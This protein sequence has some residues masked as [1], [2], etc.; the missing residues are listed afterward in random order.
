MSDK[1]KELIQASIK[2]LGV[3]FS[4]WI[5]LL[6]TGIILF[7]ILPSFIIPILLPMIGFVGGMMW[8]GKNDQLDFASGLSIIVYIVLNVLLMIGIAPDIYDVISLWEIKPVKVQ[9][10]ADLEDVPPL[11]ILEFDGW[12]TD[13]KNYTRFTKRSTNHSTNSTTTI[14]IHA[15]PL[16][17]KRK[18]SEEVFVIV[19][20]GAL[21]MEEKPKEYWAKEELVYGFVPNKMNLLGGF[22][23]IVERMQDKGIRIHPDVI[24]VELYDR[25]IGKRDMIFHWLKIKM[26]AA[27]LIWLMIHLGIFIDRAR[28]L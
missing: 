13:M 18:A 28:K 6:P 2:L 15:V 25:P 3:E 10:E 7:W 5:I 24:F 14:T 22:R 11:T 26:L 4:G 27:L 20:E 23:D 17:R 8:L 16:R 9:F 19:I 1:F 12:E 21:P